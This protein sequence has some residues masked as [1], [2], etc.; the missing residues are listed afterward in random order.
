MFEKVSWLGGF[1][2]MTH[3]WRSGEYCLSISHGWMYDLSMT[4]GW[5][6]LFENISW[7]GE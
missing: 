1:F 5:G 2:S 7:L 3:G 4:H 6:I